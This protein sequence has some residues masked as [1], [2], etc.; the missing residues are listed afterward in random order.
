MSSFLSAGNRQ[1]RKTCVQQIFDP[2]AILF[3][4]M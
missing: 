2:A 4:Q 1:R 3:G